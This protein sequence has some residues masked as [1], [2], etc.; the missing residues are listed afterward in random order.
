MRSNSH[1]EDFVLEEEVLLPRGR[2]RVSDNRVVGTSSV[3]VP[4]VQCGEANGDRNK[5][6]FKVGNCKNKHN[7]SMTKGYFRKQC[8]YEANIKISL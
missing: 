3:P 1:S 2:G 7:P 6:F 8:D 4:A 5:S